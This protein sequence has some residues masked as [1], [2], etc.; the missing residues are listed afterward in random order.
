MGSGEE[1]GQAEGSAPTTQE[2]FKQAVKADKEAADSK[3]SQVL[4]ST[5]DQPVLRVCNHNY[6]VCQR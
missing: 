5:A 1:E 4:L 3:P 6:N 2:Q